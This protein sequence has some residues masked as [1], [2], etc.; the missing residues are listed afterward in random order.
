[1]GIWC[2]LLYVFVGFWRDFCG[3][4]VR[5]FF[6][7]KCSVCSVFEDLTGVKM[8]FCVVQGEYIKT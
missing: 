1:M 4:G 3:A 6:T 5:V 7:E 2:G 8:G